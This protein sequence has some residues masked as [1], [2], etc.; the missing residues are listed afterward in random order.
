MAIKEKEVFALLKPSLDAHTLGVNAAA[1]LLRD[2]GY[3]VLTGDTRLSQIMNDIRYPSNQEKLIK[4]LKEN[5]VSYIGLSYRLDEDEAVHLVGYVMYALK[6]HHMLAIQGGPINGVSF[7]GLPKSCQII[8]EEYVGMVLTFQGSETPQETL[9]K[10]GVPPERIPKEMKEGSKYDEALLQFGKKLVKKKAYLDFPPIKRA[11]YPEFGTMEDTVLK[12]V[13]ATMT[14]NFPPLMRAHVGP[15]S[16]M[17]S[18]E[19]N[20]KEFLS[21]CTHL[22]DTKYLD[23]LSI[24]SSQLSQ[25]NFGEN[26]EE[27]PNGGGVPVNSP[28]EFRQIAEAA[29][30]MLVRT[31]SGTQNITPMAIIYENHLNIA[32]HALSLWWFNKMDGR[33]PLDVYANLKAHIETIQYIA[34]TGKPF[35]PNTPHHFS[36]RG[37]DDTTYVLSAVLAAKLAKKNGIQTFILQVMLNTPRYTWGVQDLAKARAALQLVKQL[38]DENFT[39]LLQPR[40]GLDYFS[41]DLEQARIQLAAVSALIDDIEPHNEQS[42]P[43][44]HVVSYSEASH[45]ANPPI[46]N[47]SVQ[48]TQY[49]IQEYRKLRRAGLI[50]DMNQNEDVLERTEKLVKNVR[51]LLQA[52]ETHISDPYS[53]EGFY[54]IFASGFLPTPY[55]WAERDE[56]EYAMYWKTK[57]IHGGVKVVDQEGNPASAERI[58]EYAISNIPE[59]TYRLQ[60]RREGLLI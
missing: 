23:I 22:A 11:T 7:G 14:E 35:E 6:S 29:S 58:A 18:R 43:L 60:Q 32:W 30:P 26:W 31:Y 51:I 59:I 55:I 20:V 17:V 33:G 13:Q 16:S 48:I 50:E 37:S 52:I 15:Y 25:S 38:E 12:R 28:E 10:Y 1:E 36:F 47:E 19:E 5:K 42:P 44:L 24:G 3:E 34:S 8:Q 53:A 46:I 27:R 56:F 21:W 45:L 4:W 39:V 40:A 49:A 57:P 54:T 2:C 41:P 9:G